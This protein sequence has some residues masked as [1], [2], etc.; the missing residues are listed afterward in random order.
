VA[1]RTVRQTEFEGMSDAEVDDI[2]ANDPDPKRRE[3]AQTEQ[4]A[5]GT[6][7]KKKRNKCK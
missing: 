1:G 3:R 6:R 2:A 4:K 5:R 7:N